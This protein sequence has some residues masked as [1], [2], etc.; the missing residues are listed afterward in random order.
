MWFVD[1]QVEEVVFWKGIFV[2]HPF[3]LGERL[4][5]EGWLSGQGDGRDLLWWEMVKG[6]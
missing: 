5:M 1:A 3:Y 2:T 4:R 6:Q